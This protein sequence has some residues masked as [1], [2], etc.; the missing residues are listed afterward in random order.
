MCPYLLTPSKIQF[1]IYL[2]RE[3][4]NSQGVKKYMEIFFLDGG[5]AREANQLQKQSKP[6]I[7]P[8]SHPNS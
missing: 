8:M 4:S 2:P 5:Q 7:L 3:H 6:S 1:I